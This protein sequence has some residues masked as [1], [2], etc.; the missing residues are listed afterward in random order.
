MDFTLEQYKRLLSALKSHHRYRIQHD[1]DLYPE[2]ALTI[3]ETETAEGLTSTYYIRA[4]HISSNS[5]LI[6]Q[7][8]SLGHDIGYHYENLATTHGDIEKAYTDF[9][10]HLESL[11][12]IVTV[13]TA[14]AHGSPTSPWNNKELWRHY[15]IHSLGI[16]YEPLLDTNF[17]KTL[18]LT[19]T[20]RRWD[21]YKVSVRDK[22]PQYQEQWEQ[23]GLVFHSTND[24]IHALNDIHHPIH[25]KELLINT[26]PQRWMPFGMRWIMEAGVQ[27]WK[28]QAKRLIVSSH[29]NQN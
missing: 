11:R 17:S 3:A 9:C 6:Q 5:N 25:Q 1:I 8:S 2:R 28:N 20:G 4:K 15:D 27:W 26:H 14:C 7:L 23:E 12:K 10:T 18:Y 21:G 19:D 24:I 29:L 13:K 16:D 22:V